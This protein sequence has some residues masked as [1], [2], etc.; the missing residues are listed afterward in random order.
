M[1]TYKLYEIILILGWFMYQIRQKLRQGRCYF[2]CVIPCGRFQV[3]NE[4]LYRSFRRLTPN[5][6]HLRVPREPWMVT[7][8][9]GC[10]DCKNRIHEPRG[11]PRH[12]LSSVTETLSVS[13]FSG[14]SRSLEAGGGRRR[15]RQEKRARK[16]YERLR[17]RRGLRR[18]PKPRSWRTT[19]QKTARKDKKNKKGKV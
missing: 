1:Q 11:R 5:S 7:R 15:K 19:T 4:I 3:V 9:S 17:Q 2:Y 14:E 12:I 18:K 8:S 6:R 10:S 13:A 16:D